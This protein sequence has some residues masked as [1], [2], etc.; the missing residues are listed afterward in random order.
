MALLVPANSPKRKMGTASLTPPK[1]LPLMTLFPPNPQCDYSP[2]LS[3]GIAPRRRFSLRPVKENLRRSSLKPTVQEATNSMR[4]PNN[5]RNNLRRFSMWPT[6][7][8]NQPSLFSRLFQHRSSLATSDLSYL[9]P[10][11]VPPPMPGN[12]LRTRF[13]KR[14]KYQST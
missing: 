8:N 14:E 4:Q 12:P 10:P 5:P 1:L 3:Q 9:N 2:N 7:S 13:Q 6:G 11:P